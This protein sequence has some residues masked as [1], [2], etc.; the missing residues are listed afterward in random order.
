M[1]DKSECVKVVVR[2]RPMSSTETSDGR[3][4]AVT[5]DHK[6][7]EVAVANPDGGPPKTFTFDAAYGSDAKQE[8]IYASSAYPIV[9]SVLKG[10]NGTI[11]AVSVFFS[12][13]YGLLLFLLFLEHTRAAAVSSSSTR[14]LYATCA[15]RTTL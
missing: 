6:R 11:F 7:A 4:V 2:V 8:Q 1:S 3:K 15:S 14:L 13:Y 12:L 5:A 10:F 9:E